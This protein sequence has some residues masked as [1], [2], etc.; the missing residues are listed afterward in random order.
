MSWDYTKSK[1][2]CVECGR[3]GFRISGSNEW[4]RS[5]T[6]WEGFKNQEPSP[7]AVARKRADAGDMEAVCP[8]G[9]T[10]IEIGEVIAI[11]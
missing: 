5:S 11:Y 4:G 10:E 9:S 7:T 3:V 1:A 6:T 2:R 8:C